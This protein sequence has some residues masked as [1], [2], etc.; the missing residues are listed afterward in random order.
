MFFQQYIPVKIFIFGINCMEKITGQTIH[1]KAKWCLVR[2]ADVRLDFQTLKARPKPRY[3]GRAL[4]FL[5][6]VTVRSFAIFGQDRDWSKIF[7]VQNGQDWDWLTGLALDRYNHRQKTGLKPVS[8]SLDHQF[9]RL[10]LF[11]ILCRPW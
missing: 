7:I 3:P 1:C 9:L 10:P 4:G 2:F 11:Q 8:A 6:P 5:S